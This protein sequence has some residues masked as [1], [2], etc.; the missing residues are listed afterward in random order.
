MC[1]RRH[2]QKSRSMAIAWATLQAAGA[3]SDARSR[4]C[5]AGLAPYSLCVVQS[6]AVQ[7]DALAVLERP[8]WTGVLCAALTGA[9][10]E[11]GT[12]VT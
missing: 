10:S 3:L 5:T 4:L 11:E 8:D 1:R 9:V 7:G 2:G 6:L 12:F